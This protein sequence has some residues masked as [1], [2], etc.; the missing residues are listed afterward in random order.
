MIE[1]EL[2]APLEGELVRLEPLAPEHGEGLWAA[3]QAPEIWTWLTPLDD[4]DGFERWLAQ[5]VAAVGVVATGSPIHD[6]SIFGFHL[7]LG[8]FAY[9]V[10]VVWV[11]A[12]INAM[13]LIDGMDGLASSVGVSIMSA[14]AIIGLWSGHP[15]EAVVALAVAGSLMAF[16]VY[17]FY[18]A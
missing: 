18:P 5:A 4:R 10:A 7:H 14:L 6:L 13:N 11:L 8:I 2:T 17:N 16:L 3:A 12:A 15:A 1:G 9:P